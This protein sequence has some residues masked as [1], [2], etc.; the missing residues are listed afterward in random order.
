MLLAVLM[1]ALLAAPAALAE[2]PMRLNTYV[3][4]SAGVLSGSQRSEVGDAVDT[5]FDKT[6]I[7]LWVVYVE[8]FDGM[9]WMSWAQ[10][11]EKLSD[12]GN[13]DAL[14][15]I[16]TGERSFAFVVDP[17]MTG[18]SSTL[19]DNVRRSRVEPALRKDDWAG[20]A[21]GAA[22]GLAQGKGSGS[23]SGSGGS[24]A[25]MWPV[26]VVLALAGLALWGW[27]RIRGRKRRRDEIA[28]AK[29]VDPTDP[30]QLAPLSLDAL[31][32]LARDIVVDVD[33][34]VRTSEHEL[35]LAVGEFGPERTAPFRAAVENARSA[36]SQAF[37]VRQTLDDSIP[38]TPLQRREMLTRVITSA[39][40]ADREL[41]TQTAAFEELRNLLIN[42]PDRL[43]ALTRELVAL[44]AR[45]EPAKA[46][47]Q[48][49]HEQFSDTALASVTGNIGEARDRLTFADASITRGR[50][51]LARP[52]GDQSELIDA[53]HSAEGALGQADTLLDAVDSAASDI[54]R[55]T[56][57]LPEA[58]ADI[59][60]GIDAAGTLLT[61]ADAPSAAELR[62]ARDAAVAAVQVA[63]R[64]GESD[65]LGAFG[66][67]TAA[68]ADLDRVLAVVDAARQEAE[69]QARMLDQALFTAESRVKAVSDFIDT[70]RGSIGPEART[71]LAEAVRQLEAARAKRATNPA[72][73]IAHAN[74]ASTLAAQAQTLAN[75]DVRASQRQMYGG[76]GG[77]SG[78]GTGGGSD[79]GSVLGGIIIGSMMGGG[80]GRGYGGSWG[81]GS[82]GGGRS[83]G[84]PSSYGGASRSSGRNYSG[85]RF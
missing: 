63:Q 73:A 56:A 39:G 36:L 2:P 37:T 7:K 13:D 31:D 48:G 10:Q 27:L 21:I 81:G 62:A 52:A 58:L 35:E 17:S 38:E 9:G 74:G 53:I 41:E 11:T 76:P 15:A 61:S 30:A 6:G 77:F 47:L 23:S 18:G 3:T 84:R 68:D 40:R 72:E 1:T 69:K 8:D 65:P 85:G 34:A 67:V 50:E 5:L 44:T 45:V 4:D 82:W 79:I 46:V 42:A 75:D 28:A 51:L 43:D 22:E 55:A 12:F 32:A 33:N 60:R 70:R 80:R 20:A 26:L 29:R 59:Q 49:L 78:R 16:A 64:A 57:A 24:A 71:R 83:A 54:K 25:S 14:L 66:R 19:T